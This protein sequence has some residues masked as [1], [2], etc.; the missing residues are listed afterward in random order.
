MLAGVP[1]KKISIRMEQAELQTGTE[2]RPNSVRCSRATLRA[3]CFRPVHATDDKP[4]H[5]TVVGQPRVLGGGG[6]SVDVDLGFAAAAC[7]GTKE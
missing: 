7:G 4:G 3:V 5:A 1:A 6:P 2:A